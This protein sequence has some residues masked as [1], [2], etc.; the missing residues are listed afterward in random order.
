MDKRGRYILLVLFLITACGPN[1]R[2]LESSSENR[3]ASP[4]ESN[5]NLAPAES[6]FEKDLD[7]MRNADFKFIVALRRQDGM[8]MDSA[9]KE[10][11]SRNTGSQANRRRLSDNG[12]AII[13]GSNFAF[14]PHLFEELSK[15]F[16][17]E[18][19]SKADSGPLTSNTNAMPN[20]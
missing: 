19:Y 13:I 20:R 14:V 6:S 4:V 17:V 18:N 9:D 1:Q 12:K 15:R 16:K 11:V 2:I 8:A 7:A 5:T 10:L 3:D